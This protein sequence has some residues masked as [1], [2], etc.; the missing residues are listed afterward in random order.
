MAH[1]CFGDVGGDRRDAV[2]VDHGTVGADHARQSLAGVSSC[3]SQGR[4][5]SQSALAVKCRATR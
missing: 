2:V 1:L 4:A 5:W 3:E